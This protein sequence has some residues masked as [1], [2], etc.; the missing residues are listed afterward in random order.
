MKN[1]FR[2]FQLLFF[3]FLL[4]S[5][6]LKK[7]EPFQ[8]PDDPVDVDPSWIT[9]TERSVQ[10]DENW[11]PV[12]SAVN[13]NPNLHVSNLARYEL[14]YSRG[15][16]SIQLLPDSSTCDLFVELKTKFS[17]NEISKH[18]WDENVFEF[19]YSE[20]E[21]D[22]VV[23]LRISLYYKNL[24]LDFDIA[25]AL[26]S[27]AESDTTSG[28]FKLYFEFDTPVFEINGNKFNPSFEDGTGNYFS[29]DGIGDNQFF[30]LQMSALGE[31]IFSFI[32]F[33]YLRILRFGLKDA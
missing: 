16:A 6:C 29:V 31:E 4:T 13:C 18:S 11:V 30:S 28:L 1:Q 22:S 24:E 23:E 26:R 20:Y 7:D 32:Q 27:F 19:T 3:I 2:P 21:A 14:N 17:D 25:P 15:F 8:Y 9:E 12:E 33:H 10:I 5:S